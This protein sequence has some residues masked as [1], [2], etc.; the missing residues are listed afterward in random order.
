MDGSGLFAAAEICLAASLTLASHTAD[1]EEVGPISKDTRS[2]RGW[3]EVILK[4]HLEY[5]KF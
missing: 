1:P 2:S 3:L 4:Y 5:F